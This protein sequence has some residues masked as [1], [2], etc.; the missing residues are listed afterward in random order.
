[1]LVVNSVATVALCKGSA[2]AVLGMTTNDALSRQAEAL[3][4]RYIIN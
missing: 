1:M 3:F 4:K 2:V